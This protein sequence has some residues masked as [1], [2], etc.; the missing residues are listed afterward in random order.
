M[1]VNN[2]GRENKIIAMFWL[3]S[4]NID[5]NTYNESMTP[6]FFNVTVFLSLAGVELFAVASLYSCEVFLS[7]LLLSS[8]WCVLD[9]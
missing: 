1:Q 4:L 6:T 3:L 2:E 9:R 8:F 7:L 5:I